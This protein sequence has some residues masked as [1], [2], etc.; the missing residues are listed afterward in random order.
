MWF[1]CGNQ[2]TQHW[3]VLYRWESTCMTQCMSPGMTASPLWHRLESIKEMI[4]GKAG[5]KSGSGGGS[6]TARRGN[7]GS[8]DVLKAIIPK[9][10]HCL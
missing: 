8:M 7:L 6:Y 5:F 4:R 10:K 9:Q 3:H 1:R 2:K